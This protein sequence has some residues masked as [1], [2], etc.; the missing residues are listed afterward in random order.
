MMRPLFLAAAVALLGLAACAPSAPAIDKKDPFKSLYPWNHKWSQ[1][2]KTEHGVEYII[3]SK[4][5]G[6][7]P[8]PA[9]ND[10]V[11]VNYDGRL[12]ANGQQ[13]DSSYGGDPSVFRLSDV[14]PGWTEG[15]QKMQPGDQ[16]MFW[17]PS[18]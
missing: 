9:P 5:D 2:Q 8:H 16:F 14:I 7:G 6:K 15:L 12:A 11:E 10:R 3:V 18:A 1:I 13:F 17:F 4:G